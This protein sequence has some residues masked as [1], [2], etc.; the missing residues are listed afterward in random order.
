MSGSAEILK[1]ISESY[2][3]MRNTLRF[4][5][6][7]LHGFDP[8]ADQVPVGEMV[9]LDRWVLSRAAELQA[10]ILAAYDTYEFHRVYQLLHNFCVVDLGGFYLDVI[11]DRLYTTPRAGR[12]RRS[13]Q[14]A[15]YH[16]AEAM[17]RWLAPVLS[18]TAEEIWKAL[19]GARDVTVF[20]STWHRLPEA[21]ERSADWEFLLGVREV[22]ARAL[23]ALRAAGRIGSGLDAEVRLYADADKGRALQLLGEELRFVFITSAASVHPAASRPVDAIAG[24]GYWV[25]AGPTEAAK[26]VR[27]WHRREDVGAVAPHPEI[28]ERCATNVEGPGERRA[29]A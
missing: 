20:T 29:F 4:L 23:E 26:C 12:P 18:F 3:R 16:I 11:K 17:V 2:R 1:R 5:L 14:T 27:C 8:G 28:C 25:A 10:E 7:N 13:A 15:M 24:D 19:P 22:V 9:D 21:G 6:G